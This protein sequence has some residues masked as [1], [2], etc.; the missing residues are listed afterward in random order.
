MTQD[1]RICTKC[2]E[3]K[4][5]TC[6]HKHKGCKGGLN[7]VC[8]VCRNP[9]SKAQWENKTIEYKIWHRAKSRAKKKNIEFSL[10]IDDIVV[11][12][13]CPVLKTPI[14]VPSIDRHNPNLGYTKENIVIM[15]NRANILKNNGTLD[16]FKKIVKYLES[17]T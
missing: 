4:P 6:F 2:G 5:R 16:E 10:C 11:P 14:D 17:K 7:S 15:S 1:G 13:I 12:K 3:H 9:L 8:K